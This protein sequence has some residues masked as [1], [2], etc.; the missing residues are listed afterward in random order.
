MMPLPT[1]SAR[2]SKSVAI[3]FSSA[4]LIVL[5]AAC[6]LQRERC[7]WYVGAVALAMAI[8]F[9]LPPVGWKRPHPYS[10]MPGNRPKAS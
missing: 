6:Y 2:D 1:A 9:A 5:P 10:D 8:A 4:L 7:W 3:N